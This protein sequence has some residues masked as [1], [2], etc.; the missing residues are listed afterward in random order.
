MKYRKLTFK[1]FLQAEIDRIHTF[2][3]AN[4]ALKS[5]LEFINH[6]RLSGILSEFSS[7][8]IC[9][10]FHRSVRQSGPPAPLTCPDPEAVAV[11]AVLRAWRSG[12]CV[13]R[14]GVEWVIWV[15]FSASSLWDKTCVLT[16]SNGHAGC[17]VIAA[18]LSR[19][20]APDWP[21]SLWCN[22][23]GSWICPLWSWGPLLLRVTGRCGLISNTPNEAC[24]GVT[25]S[26]LLPGWP[27]HPSD[28]LHD[29]DSVTSPRE[30][31]RR[32]Q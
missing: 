32:C 20:M 8:T 12:S 7:D 24:V 2:A 10:M 6:T 31:G 21:L 28:D 30:P 3:K 22:G 23:D 13:R 11:S 17:L 14:E 16:S 25:G 9:Q 1:S 27:L 19:L 15:S 5:P 26:L 4:L 18:K 29:S